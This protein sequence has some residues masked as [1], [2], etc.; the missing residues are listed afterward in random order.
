MANESVHKALEQAIAGDANALEEVRNWRKKQKETTHRV[1]EL[2][3]R[4]FQLS[5]KHW[6]QSIS[7]M[8]SWLDKA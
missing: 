5:E 8:R 1:E 3:L 2:K 7:I 4:L 6:D